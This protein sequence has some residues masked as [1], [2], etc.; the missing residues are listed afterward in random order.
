MVSNRRVRHFLY[1][2][3]SNPVMRRFSGTECM[4]SPRPPPV[5]PRLSAPLI[6]LGCVS[7]PVLEGACWCRFL[8]KTSLASLKQ[9]LHMSPVNQ[10]SGQLL[11]PMAGVPVCLYVPRLLSFFFS[12]F[13]RPSISAVA[14][15]HLQTD[16][17][18]RHSCEAT[19]FIQ[20]PPTPLPTTNLS[21][22]HTPL[23]ML[24]F[25]QERMNW[26]Q[27]LKSAINVSFPRHNKA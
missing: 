9:A 17:G 4:C 11:S 21:L 25:Q 6:L 24:S 1:Q 12:F 26:L 16:T 10:V 20:Q 3:A 2:S 5:Q 15:N 13:H 14:F 23:T 18:A 27:R 22:F 19:L 8:S 7:H